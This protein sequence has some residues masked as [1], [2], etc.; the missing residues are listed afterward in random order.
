MEDSPQ[1][2]GSRK[3]APHS[4]TAYRAIKDA[5]LSG[6]LEVEKPLIEEA[7]AGMLSISH[8]P[9]RE[10]L[11]ILEHEGL[12]GPRHGRG[13]Y[14]RPITRAEFVEVF[15]ANEIVAQEM[16]RR[17]ARFA[18]EEQLQV[19]GEQVSREVYYAGQANLPNFFQASRDFL[20]LAGEAAEN[21]P[22]ANFLISTQERIDLYLLSSG[23]TLALEHLES[24]ARQHRTLLNALAHRDPDE[25]TRLVIAYSQWL[26]DQLSV[27][28]R[29]EEEEN[30]GD[31]PDLSMF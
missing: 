1:H 16:I 6:R 23:K 13:L 3:N 25:A 24:F 28:F 10:A 11:T 9:V 22:L 4:E 30:Q 12:I 31:I 27:V 14:V 29:A 5:I 7:L 2:P 15:T 19:L 17:A 21:R 18:T 8:T 26:R 20:R